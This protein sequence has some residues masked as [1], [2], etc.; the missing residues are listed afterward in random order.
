MKLCHGCAMQNCSLRAVPFRA[1]L[2]QRS[3]A[4]CSF[5]GRAALQVSC[6]PQPRVVA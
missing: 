2:S 1:L 3:C 4:K 5:L 6:L